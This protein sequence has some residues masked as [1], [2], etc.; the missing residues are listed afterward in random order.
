MKLAGFPFGHGPNDAD[1]LAVQRFVSTG[2]NYFHVA[3]FTIF[4]HDELTNNAPFNTFAIRLFGVTSVE[5]EVI[6]QSL[7]SAGKFG[8]WIYRIKNTFFI[9]HRI[10]D[11]GLRL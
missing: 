2:T 8:H 9:I 1:S 10:C 11:Y 4:L 5:T 7:L 6:E 3:D